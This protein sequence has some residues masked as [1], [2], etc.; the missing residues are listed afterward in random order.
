MNN[1]LEC[2]NFNLKLLALVCTEAEA[3]S[4]CITNYQQDNFNYILMDVYWSTQ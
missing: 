1:L 3:K 2:E 4:H